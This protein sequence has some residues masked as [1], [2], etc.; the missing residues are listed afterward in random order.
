VRNTPKLG[1]RYNKLE[2]PLELTVISDSAFKALDYQGL[3]MRGCVVVL[4]EAGQLKKG[5]RCKVQVLDWYSKKHTHVVRSTYAAELHSLLDAVNQG[6]VLIYALT[7]LRSGALTALDLVKRLGAGDWAIPM[8]ACIDAKAVFD[9]I[10]ADVVKTPYDKHLLVHALAVREFL[11]SRSVH[12]LY[13]IDTNDMLADGLTKG[14]IDRVSLV[15]ATY[16]GEW[17]LS[18]LSPVLYQEPGVP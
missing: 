12:S 17:V 5:T 15:L 3:V 6:L 9:N 11:R 10:V 8:S 7:E 14:S 18:G 4:R 16:I 1:L 13:W 2:E